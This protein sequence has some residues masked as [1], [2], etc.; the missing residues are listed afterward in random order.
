MLS[1]ILRAT[2]III[3]PVAQQNNLNRKWLKTLFS[4][5]P[6]DIENAP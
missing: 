2:A 4:V 1:L 5:A 3:K 6:Y